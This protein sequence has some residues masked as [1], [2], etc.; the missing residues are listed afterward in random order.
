M[1]MLSTWVAT[2][3][4]I[5]FHPRSYLQFSALYILNDCLLLLPGLITQA[6]FDALTGSAPAA[7]GVWGLLAL[8]AAVGVTRIVGNYLRIYGKET[9]RCSGWALLRKN[10]LANVLRRPGAEPLPIPPG[11]AVSRVRWDVMP[12][13]ARSARFIADR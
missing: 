4:L 9:F 2:W 12:I 11:D 5:R 8:L 7:F 13:P 1:K 6:F 3:K 10:I